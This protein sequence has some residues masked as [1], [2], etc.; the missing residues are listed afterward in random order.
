M[1]VSTVPNRLSHLNHEIFIRPKERHDRPRAEFGRAGEGHPLVRRFR[2][3]RNSVRRPQGCAGVEREIRRESRS[4]RRFQN[5]TAGRSGS[6][7]PMLSGRAYDSW[8]VVGAG[9]ISAD[10][11]GI[12]GEIADNA[13][14]Y[15]V[16]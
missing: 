2:A 16:G 1:A 7:T 6:E 14:N 5:P 11:L 9:L 3:G 8:R 12:E 4:R 10:L 15:T 13:P